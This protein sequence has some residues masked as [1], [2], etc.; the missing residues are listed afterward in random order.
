MAQAGLNK[1]RH[2]FL[3]HIKKYILHVVPPYWKLDSIP[4]G[5]FSTLYSYTQGWE[6]AHSLI[7]SFRTNQM[8]DCERFAQ[9]A[10]DKWETVSALLRSL[11]GNERSWTNRSGRSPKMSKWVNESFFERIAHS[12][13]F[14]QKTWAIRSEIK[15]ANSQPWLCID[16]SFKNILVS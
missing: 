8:S 1:L 14:G 12:L 3:V 7:P 9:I 2:L 11:R 6:F 4:F 16:M 15:W 13:I 10:Q 5:M